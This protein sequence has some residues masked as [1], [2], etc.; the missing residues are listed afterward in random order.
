MDERSKKLLKKLMTK[1]Q[2][3][4][5]MKTQR[6]MVGEGKKLGTKTMDSE[7]DYSRQKEK[8]NVRKKI[9]EYRSEDGTI[10]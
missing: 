4:Q 3:E 8:R 9:R 5:Y 7:K 10:S 1:K 2:L 6:S